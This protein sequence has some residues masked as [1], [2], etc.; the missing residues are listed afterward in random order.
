M[1]R[2]RYG[3]GGQS[4]RRWLSLVDIDRR[5]QHR[6]WWSRGDLRWRTAVIPPLS[7]SEPI[8]IRR[9]WSSFRVCHPNPNIHLLLKWLTLATHHQKLYF[10]ESGTSFKLR[11]CRV[12]QI[13]RIVVMLAEYL[14]PNLTVFNI[15]THMLGSLSWYNRFNEQNNG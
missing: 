3:S 9:N 14:A 11:W 7:S 6:T 12:R 13:H 8:P 1:R 2:K 5:T 15:M 4:A 10:R